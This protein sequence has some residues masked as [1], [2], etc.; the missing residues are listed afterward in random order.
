LKRSFVIYS[1]QQHPICVDFQQCVLF[2]YISDEEYRRMYNV[3]CVSMIYF[4]PLFVIIYCYSFIVKFIITHS[5]ELRRNW[6]ITMNQ[7]RLMTENIA[8]N[9]ITLAKKK[10]ILTTMLIVIAFLLCWTPYV[11][12]IMWNQI[13]PSS[14]SSLN[15]QL[16]DIL[17]VFAVSNSCINPIV[18]G[19]HKKIVEKLCFSGYSNCF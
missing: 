18:Y 3:F 19:N 4:V 10:T 14:A 5:K 16:Q 12:L 8:I 6:Y 1:V 7:N 2:N 15:Y 9:R 17:F 13:H 11:L